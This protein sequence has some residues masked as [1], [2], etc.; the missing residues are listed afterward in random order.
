MIQILA[1]QQPFIYG[2]DDWLVIQNWIESYTPVQL[3]K[4]TFKLEASLVNIKRRKGLLLPSRYIFI[5]CPFK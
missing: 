2:T 1:P 4:L 5:A 3:G